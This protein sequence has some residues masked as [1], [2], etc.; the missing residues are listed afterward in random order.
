MTELEYSTK[1]IEEKIS[2]LRT[3]TSHLSTQISQRE[4]QKEFVLSSID[5]LKD[6][7]DSLT[8]RI[9]NYK[10]IETYLANFADERQAQVYRQLEV[11]VSEG[12]Q[13]VFEEDIRLEVENKMVGSRAETVF[14][15]V[16]NTEEGELRTGIMDS[17]GGGVSAVV[18]FLIQ[19]VL[20]LL[21][22]NMRPLL[23]LDETFRNVSTDLQGR[24][25]EWISDL[26][27]KTGLQVILVTHQPEIAE[28]ADVHYS[29]T[30]RGGKTKIERVH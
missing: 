21:T 7:V 28:H 29:F 14:T 11:T 4:G 18:G 19:A 3:K 10:L 20:V 8:E 16:S 26:C 1:S 25:G 13:S 17:R 22:P 27:N 15:L 24:L 2:D 12:L 5:R 6:S 23:A 9:D 30:Q